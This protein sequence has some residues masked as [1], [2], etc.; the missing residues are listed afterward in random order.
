MPGNI[1]NKEVINI[2][3]YNYGEPLIHSDLGKSGLDIRL[4]K[5]DDAKN[6]NL[7]KSFLSS[8]LSS[9]LSSNAIG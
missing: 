5:K 3:T 2:F 9:A 7:I 6:T 8:F 1:T 4:T